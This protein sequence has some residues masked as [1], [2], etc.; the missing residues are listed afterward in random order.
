M[1]A[2][3]C[4]IRASLLEV[5]G[6]ISD[7]SFE[8]YEAY[9]LSKI[10]FYK[11]V[12]EFCQARTDNKSFCKLASDWEKEEK[13]G[14]FLDNYDYIVFECH[15][16]NAL[17]STINEEAELKLAVE[18]L[19]E[20]RDRTQIKI[21]KDRVSAYIHLLQ[22]LAD[23][24][25]KDSYKEAAENVKEGCRIFREYGDEQGQQMCDIFNNAIVKRRDPNAWQ[26]II[27]KRE[28]SSNF[29]SLLCEYSDRKRADLEFYRHGQMQEMMGT[30]SKDVEQVKNASTL[31]ENKVDEVKNDLMSI[32]EKVDFIIISLKPG[33]KEEIEISSGIEMF[34]TGLKHLVTIPLQEISY[35]E[36]KKD[37]K[38]I[39]GKHINKLSELPIRLASKI[40]G[41]LS[42]T[43]R[44]DI[45][46][47][48]YTHLRAHETDSYLVC[49]LL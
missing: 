48:S 33:I 13:E 15:L 43:G 31:I 10:N 17:K 49:R 37:L 28:F 8:Y 36:L 34:G 3:I 21:I 44:E 19:K 27:R 12:K 22:A 23:C 38:I 16:E 40:K 45:I 9:K 18:K 32:S 20:I 26:D 4:E 2:R 42:R 1:L 29:Y 14:I 35:E 46:A 11:F 6:K 41:Y 25:N 30:I 47:V 39:K 7:A 5:D 24:F